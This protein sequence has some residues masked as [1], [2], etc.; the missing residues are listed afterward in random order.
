[1]ENL[2]RR[3]ARSLE[4]HA[5]NPRDILHDKQEAAGEHVRHAGEF[6]QQAAHTLG[7][8]VR[9]P[10]L[11]P[12]RGSVRAGLALLVHPAVEPTLQEA[13]VFGGELREEEA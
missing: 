3:L 12:V 13:V 4:R 10:V 2:A 8:E 9:L 6:L 7:D 5:E 1:M 11:Q